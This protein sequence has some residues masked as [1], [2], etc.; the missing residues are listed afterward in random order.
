L[1]ERPEPPSSDVLATM[2]R[3]YAETCIQAFG[4]S[5]S[6]FES[7]FPVDKVSYSY[8]VFW[9][10]CKILTKGASQAEKRDL[11]AETAARFYRLNVAV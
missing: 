5:R 9:N 10:A 11:F 7:N 2:W 3:P 8:P 1:N 4:A 6:M